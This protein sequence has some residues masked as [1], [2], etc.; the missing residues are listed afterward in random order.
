MQ[1][2][3]DWELIQCD[4]GQGSGLLARNNGKT[5]LIDTGPEKSNAAA[6]LRRNSVKNLDLLVI[7]HLD[8]DH[9]GGFA[10]VL[11][12]AQVREIWVSE[13]KNPKYRFAWLKNLLM[14]SK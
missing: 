3:F 4:V 6:C 14:N 2:K 5:I 1:Q 11:K 7:S 8:A 13:N 9:V 10:A 12:H